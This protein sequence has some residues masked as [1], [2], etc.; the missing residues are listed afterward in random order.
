MTSQVTQ[1][2]GGEK[3]KKRSRL[4]EHKAIES[5]LGKLELL[6]ANGEKKLEELENPPTSVKLSNV[7][8]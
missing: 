5:C 1:E 2:V 7:R 6:M 8:I 4:V 3:Q